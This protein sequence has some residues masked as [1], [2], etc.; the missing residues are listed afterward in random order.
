MKRW[1]FA[2]KGLRKTTKL[3]H[4]YI[5]SPDP[6][7]FHRGTGRSLG[8]CA[9]TGATAPLRTG[10]SWWDC[11][12]QSQGS[13]LA[14]VGSGLTPESRVPEFSSSFHQVFIKFSSSFHQVFIKFSSSSHQVFIKFS[15]SFHQVHQFIDLY[16]STTYRT[17]PEIHP[18]HSSGSASASA[19]SAGSARSA[20][21]W[22]CSPRDFGCKA[23]SAAS[24][25]SFLRPEADLRRRARNNRSWN[26]WKQNHV[27]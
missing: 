6:I 21:G 1:A 11:I 20:G 19:G 3:W 25:V 13:R 23:S 24:R 9:H 22:A 18:V 17:V 7:I 15:S 27:L 5:G 2:L 4:N 10:G 26:S 14:A 12:W 8:R 16:R